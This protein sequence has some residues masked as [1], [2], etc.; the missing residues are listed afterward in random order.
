MWPET[1][2][3]TFSEALECGLK[4]ITFNMGAPV[5]RLPVGCGSFVELGD[6]YEEICSKIV[7][8]SS[9][10]EV[11]ITTGKTYKSYLSEY[12][13]FDNIN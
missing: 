10:P 7:E 11:K 3:Y 8:L 1:F 4:I 13:E 12:Y 9:L 2:S 5:E 6:D